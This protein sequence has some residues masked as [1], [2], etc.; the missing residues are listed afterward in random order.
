MNA[1]RAWA[2]DDSNRRRRGSKE[3]KSDGA[4]R[5]DCSR[6]KRFQKLDD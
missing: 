1:K 2:V 4:L 3:I 5:C 6:S